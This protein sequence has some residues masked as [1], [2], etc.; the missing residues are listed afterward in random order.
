MKDTLANLTILAFPSTGA[1]ISLLVGTFNLGV[2]AVLQ[3]KVEG[4]QFSPGLF[5]RALPPTQQNYSTFDSK[6]SGLFL[7]IKYFFS[8]VEGRP[9]I[10]W[11][12]HAPLTHAIQSALK[13]STRHRLR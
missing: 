7:G 1:K 2:E 12:E 8:F 6:L 3:Q 9:I 5:S 4:R 11:T 10:I 13:E